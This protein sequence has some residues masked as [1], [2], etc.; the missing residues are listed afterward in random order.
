MKKIV[1]IIFLVVITYVSN[2]QVLLININ[3]GDCPKCQLPLSQLKQL[4]DKIPSYIV[5]SE[6][7]Y[8]DRVEINDQFEYRK[9]GYNTIFADNILQNLNH[10]VEAFVTLVD[11][12]NK[13][14]WEK[15][16]IAIDQNDIQQILKLYNSLG[17]KHNNDDVLRVHN[18]KFYNYN[19]AINKIMVFN[20]KD[21]ISY[22]IGN[23]E[24][25][26]LIK[27][28]GKKIDEKLYTSL[29]SENPQFKPSYVNYYKDGDGPL[30]IMSRYYVPEKVGNDTLVE[31]RSALYV[32]K[33]KRQ[34]DIFPI[35]APRDI[36]NFT[37]AN[38]SYLLKNDSILIINAYEH[39]R[40]PLKNCA[41]FISVFKLRNNKFVYDTQ[42]QMCLPDVYKK[43]L[44][45]NFISFMSLD[46]PYMILPLGKEIY[47]INSG[48]V[49]TISF[50]KEVK[51][52]DI[53]LDAL[54]S[55]K[56]NPVMNVYLKHS[57]SKN[58]IFIV[59]Q[60]DFKTYLHI[61]NSKTYERLLS[62][63]LEEFIPN[64]KKFG[65]IDIDDK[66][67]WLCYLDKNDQ[68]RYVPL[69]IINS[70]NI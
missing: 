2:A 18:D 64:I 60:I 31:Q 54:A 4:N 9:L 40:P 24:G 50:S 59:N 20:D 49:R 37:I 30:S 58:Q 27:L 66:N 68:I 10:P 19:S 57:S 69:G 51:Y 28:I 7:L 53:S 61:Y 70:K 17:L 8:V 13:V 11:K 65:I 32:Y 55:N 38:Y 16:L 52:E 34:Y 35:V 6:K 15:P 43:K 1:L 21:T 25:T 62:S 23:K 39:Q 41:Q 5:L 67:N 14:I 63:E 44:G 48:E 47:N 22:R 36:N 3:L 26:E 56:K 45:Y 12:T 46:Y 29:I 42:L 33:D